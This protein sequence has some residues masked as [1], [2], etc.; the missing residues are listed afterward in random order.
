MIS[1]S[2]FRLAD[3]A[4]G[5][6]D[7]SL[8]PGCSSSCPGSDDLL[9]VTFPH[10]TNLILFF[11]GSIAIIMIVVG[12]LRY[13]TSGGNA[14]AVNDAKNTILYAIVGLVVA[15]SAYA[16]VGYITGQFGL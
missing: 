15:A 3:T 10:V 8:K 16:L 7:K 11:V 4:S 9:K 13:V 1:Q 6:I 12:G 2:L 14:A 5:V